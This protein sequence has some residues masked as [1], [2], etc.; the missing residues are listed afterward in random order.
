MRHMHLSTTPCQTDHGSAFL[1][2][3]GLWRSPGGKSGKESACQY[4]RR[5]R[6]LHPWVGKI[7]WRRKRQPTP[8]FL[9]GKVHGQ[10]S[11]AGY[12]PWS[13]EELD[14]WMQTRGFQGDGQG[15][16]WGSPSKDV[17]EQPGS[18]SMYQQGG[19]RGGAT[20]V[21]RLR[22]WLGVWIYWYSS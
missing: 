7:P 14:T 9:P 19:W 3:V 21:L 17:E 6:C 10:R 22:R 13:R 20:A 5:K 12:S 15:P 16:A 11:L 1:G 4:W 2:V 18:G 8:V